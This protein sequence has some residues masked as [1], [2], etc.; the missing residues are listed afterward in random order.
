M[1]RVLF[2]IFLI[3]LLFVQS[4]SKDSNLTIDNFSIEEAK[5][6]FVNDYEQAL[7]TKGGDSFYYS[8]SGGDYTPMW[9]LAIS[10]ENEYI[11]SLEVPIVSDLAVVV[12]NKRALKMYKGFGFKRVGKIP[13][14]LQYLDGSFADEYKMVKYLDE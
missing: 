2:K 3:S 6:S 11:W 4:C 1:K 7:S 14:A 5:V 10:N 9:D 8:L 12:K 13:R